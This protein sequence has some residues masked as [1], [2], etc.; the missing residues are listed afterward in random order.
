MR[1]DERL[2]RA[3]ALGLYAVDP[4]SGNYILGSPLFKRA[5][6]DVGNGRTL[7]IVANNSSAQNVYVQSLTWNG[8][9]INRSWMRHADLAAGGT[10]E[11]SMGAKPNKA[12]GANKEDLPPSFG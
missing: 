10:L 2:V 11:F 6:L 1:A 3:S 7:R 9:P 5:E 4:V 8:K 12:F